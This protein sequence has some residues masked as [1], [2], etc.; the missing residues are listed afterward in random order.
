MN[1]CHFQ[2]YHNDFLSASTCNPQNTGGMVNFNQNTI[3]NTCNLC[4]KNDHLFI[5]Q[6]GY[7]FITYQLQVQNC[8]CEQNLSA[9]LCLNGCKLDASVASSNCD[10]LTNTLIIYCEANSVITLNTC[11]EHFKVCNA[12]LNIFKL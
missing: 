6:A 11:G 4:M 1:N 2:A 12:S 3:S 9:Y 10:Q 8:G 7:Y 5:H